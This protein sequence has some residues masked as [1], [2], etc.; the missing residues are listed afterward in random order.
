MLEKRKKC[1]TKL[2]YFRAGYLSTVSVLV[3]KGML[4]AMFVMKTSPS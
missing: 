2:V 1:W 4:F 3:L